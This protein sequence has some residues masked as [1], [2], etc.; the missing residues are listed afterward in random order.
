MPFQ[1][2]TLPELLFQFTPL[3]E[4]RRSPPQYRPDCP[5][6]NS[7][8]CERGDL[9]MKDWYWKHF[10]FNSRPCERGDPHG[11]GGDRS[12]KNFNSRPCE[13]GDAFRFF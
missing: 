7:R 6:F 11:L 1:L 5:H 3:R 10:N 4:G 8:P 9:S 2:F 13:R 12:R